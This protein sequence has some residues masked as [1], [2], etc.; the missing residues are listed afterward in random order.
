MENM[1]R[2]TINNDVIKTEEDLLVKNEG[3]IKIIPIVSGSAWWFVPILIGGGA[4]GV[5]A[6]TTATSFLFVLGSALIATGVSMGIQGVT[7]LLFPQQTPEISFSG[8]SETDARVNYS[9]N[10]IQNVSRSGVCIPLIYG[11]VFCG[12]IVVSS[13]TDTAP[14]FAN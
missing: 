6:A 2:I 4:A 5:T 9:F 13:G 7:N 14:V 12:S 8:L 10:G 3:E 1:Y 11:E